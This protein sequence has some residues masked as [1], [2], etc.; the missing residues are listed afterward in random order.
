MVKESVKKEELPPEDLQPGDSVK[1]FATR[2]KEQI[3]LKKGFAEA[4]SWK[5]IA[6]QKKRRRRVLRTARG[7]IKAEAKSFENRSRCLLR[8][9]RVKT[10]RGA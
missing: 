5:R 10:D 2:S 8:R 6:V 9:R 1:H 4:K 7:A 3:A